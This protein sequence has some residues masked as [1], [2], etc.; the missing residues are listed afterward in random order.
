MLTPILASSKDNAPG[1]LYRDRLEVGRAL[2]EVQYDNWPAVIPYYTYDVEYHDPVVDIY[3]IDMMTEFLARLLGSSPDLVTT[4][5]DETLVDGVYSAT[6]TMAGQFAGSPYKAKGV[7]IMKFGPESR[8]VYYQRDYYSEGD[9]MAQILGLDQ[10]ISAFRTVYRCAVDPTFDCPLE[11][12]ANNDPPKTEPSEGSM[13]YDNYVNPNRPPNSVLEKQMEIGRALI[14][15]NAGS[16]PAV[17]PYLTNEY[18][19]HDPIVDIY[20]PGTMA[21]FLGRLFASSSDLITTVEDET[22]RNGVYMAT[23]T[24]SGQFNGVPFSAPGMSIVKFRGWSTRAYYSRDYYT[25]GDI[26]INIPQL[27]EAV[28]GFRTFY[29]CA[30]DPTFDCPLEPPQALASRE[31][32]ETI[33]KDPRPEYSFELRQNFPNPFNP[34]TTISFVV[35]DG[36]A[37]VTLRV[38]DSSGRLVRT[39]A[40]GYQPSGVREVS[41]HGRNDEGQAV[42]SGV[43]FYKLTGPS[44]SNTRKMVLLR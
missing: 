14:E 30:V 15:L 43:Y 35:P 23:W 39:L 19:Y 33:Q 4:I 8:Q 21:E 41:W 10:A 31:G 1:R 29:R 17:I 12:A 13:N 5:E 32:G 36:G 25:E 9:I 18:E 44:F 37:N 26:M 34:T 24:M 16:W 38:Y 11:T 20:G 27:T 7:T 22:L 3:G 6:W 40:D 2:L 28:T 42:P